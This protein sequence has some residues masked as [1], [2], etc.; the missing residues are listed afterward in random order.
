MSFLFKTLERLVC[1]RNDE[2]AFK[3]KPF[4]NR[5]Y[6]FRKG[7]STER[8][9][10]DAL[11]I[12]EKGFY[13]GDYV[14]G[15]FLDIKGAFDNITT[16]AIV[17]AL[18][19]K[20]VERNIIRW[21]DQYL[22]NRVC[23]AELGE[24]KRK[25]KLTKG[26]PQGGV[27]SPVMAWNCAFDMLLEAFDGL[28]TKIIGYADDALLLTTSIDLGTAL[29]LAQKAIKKAE[30]WARDVG[31]EFSP[32]K[33]SV[34]IFTRKR[35]KPN[36]K[37]KI[38]G[39]EVDFVSSTKY[40]G[41]VFDNKLTFRQHIE[42][43]IAAAR[44]ALIL[45]KRAFSRTWGPKPKK[46]KWL[47]TGV[48]RPALLYGCLIWH[49]AVD[50]AI[51]KDKLQRLQRLALLTIANVRKGTPTAAMEIIFNLPPLDLIIKEMAAK[52]YVRLNI[53]G[54]NYNCNSH[55]TAIEKWLGDWQFK[56]TSSDNNTNYRL[57]DRK[58]DV[59][60]KDGS[61]TEMRDDGQIRC[62]TDGSRLDSRAGAGAVV[63][64]GKEIQEIFKQGIGDRSV[65]QAE[66]Q[67][68][69]LAAEFLQGLYG[70]DIKF[71]V[72]S[73]AAIKALGSD[74][75]S[76]ELVND[77]YNVL[78]EISTRNDV[79]VEWIK[80]HVG[81]PGNEL[82]D[83][84]AK[85]GSKLD[86]TTTIQPPKRDLWAAIEGIMSRKWR[87]R[88]EGIKTCRQ[89]KY[90]YSGPDKGKSDELLNMTK[91]KISVLTRFLT[92]HVF[93]RRQNFIVDHG[94]YPPRGWASCRLCSEGNL[95]EDEDET[96]HHLITKCPALMVKRLETL[97]HRVLDD[98]PIW[99][100]LQLA[101]LLEGQVERLEE[102]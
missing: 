73:Q 48:I 65:F 15:C 101:G 18:E 51:I 91:N 32:E 77:T 93:L 81:W 70:R 40:L 44:K 63:F 42:E 31:V 86:N 11:K 96:P 37:L 50:S 46:T 26:A 58:F 10:S 62:Y 16:G 71:R 89:T 84:A 25:I 28:A 2:T 38:Y 98:N 7:Y 19:K 34:M 30:N 88:W 53:E 76:S 102:T 66:L 12:I 56:G 87:R 85:E 74:E 9:M 61:D 5:Q 35:G 79:T 92:G 60:I 27:A 95:E 94:C 69:K 52:T 20:N 78:Q 24:A 64:E 54:I 23:T 43:K 39:K 3:D 100:P 55:V 21:Y 6:A 47:Y 49:K 4:H 57:K 29:D 80:A 83:E 22:N 67:A 59:L 41:V 82:A 17:R 97:G 13:K 90:F 1:W 75:T 99:R 68:I 33:T 45:A 36:R 8:A 14:V 72:D